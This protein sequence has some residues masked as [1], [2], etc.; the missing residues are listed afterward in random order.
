MTAQLDAIDQR[1]LSR[2]QQDGR[3]TNIELADD[4]GLSAS[5]C[6]RRVK[7]MEADGVIAGYTA[8]LDRRKLG[9]D[10]LA[11]VDVK[12]ERHSDEAAQ[13]FR[14]AVRADP[15]V[16]ACYALTGDRD[17][18][19]TVATPSLDDF[20]AFDMHRLMRIPGVKEVRTSLV[21]ETIKDGASLP[22][23]HLSG[24]GHQS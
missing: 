16:I 6:L 23:D 5:P 2:L 9:L 21:L 1:I 17:F 18:L 24:T 12:I 20:A 3:L 14:D 15:S 8:R 4:V 22:L 19:L 7:K 13:A 11:F 10:I